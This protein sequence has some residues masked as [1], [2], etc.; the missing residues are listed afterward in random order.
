MILPL[1]QLTQPIWTLD[2]GQAM[3][4]DAPKIQG[5]DP[6]LLLSKSGPCTLS[7]FLHSINPLKYQAES[8]STGV[9]P[10]DKKPGFLPEI[11]D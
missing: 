10:K 7:L 6:E 5:N 3:P 2:C 1:H 9:N 4:L 11:G 8:A